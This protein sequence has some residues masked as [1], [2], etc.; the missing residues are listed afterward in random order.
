MSS[1]TQSWNDLISQVMGG[2]KTSTAY[3]ASIKTTTPPTAST[4]W[5]DV[6]N[7]LIGQWSG[8]VAPPPAANKID[9]QDCIDSIMSAIDR[10]QQQLPN[11][12]TI[13]NSTLY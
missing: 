4:N 9:V 2:M 12:T 10:I 6:M 13:T 1:S 8:S 5:E 7:D 3:Q 11:S